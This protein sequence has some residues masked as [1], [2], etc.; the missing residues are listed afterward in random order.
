MSTSSLPTWTAFRLPPEVYTLPRG[1]VKIQEFLAEDS[2]FNL[3]GGPL[4]QRH[5]RLATEYDDCLEQDVS[6]AYLPEADKPPSILRLHPSSL[7]DPSLYRSRQTKR[8]TVKR[9]NL[10][11]HRRDQHRTSVQLDRKA[12]TKS[13]AA[14]SKI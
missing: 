3:D 9:F 10:T 13:T 7:V 1:G 6:P 14:A 12:V 5:R 4:L 2:K 8:R 11:W